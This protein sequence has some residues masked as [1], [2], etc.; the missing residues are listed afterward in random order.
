MPTPD[1]IDVSTSA[2]W[3]TA[4]SGGQAVITV[5]AFNNSAPLKG[6][7]VALAVG[8]QY[9]TI[10]PISAITDAFII[11]PWEIQRGGD[12]TPRPSSRPWDD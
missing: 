2:E 9:G 6:A 11:Y 5:Q 7:T 10:V 8:S 4:G 12:E 3:L 1:Q